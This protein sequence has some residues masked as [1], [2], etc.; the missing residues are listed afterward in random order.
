MKEAAAIDLQAVRRELAAEAAA[1]GFAALG[2]AGIEIP[3]DEQ[4]LLRWLEQGFHGEMG[5]MARHGVMRSRPQQLA[6]GT[7]RVV[8]ARIDYWPRDATA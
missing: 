6:P 1:L 4:H 3:E 2:V 5:Y 8:S 7:V